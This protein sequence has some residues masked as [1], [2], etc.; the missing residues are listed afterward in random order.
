MYIDN[1]AIIG[2]RFLGPTEEFVAGTSRRCRN[3]NCLVDRQIIIFPD[4]AC[5]TVRVVIKPPDVRWG[6]V[7]RGSVLGAQLHGI[8]LGIG[9][10]LSR[11]R[12][13]FCVSIIHPETITWEDLLVGVDILGSVPL[14][15]HPVLES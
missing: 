4:D 2:L 9:I 11:S 6:R 15:Y 5:I 12:F 14:L 8:G 10:L 1:V 3:L 7:L 13:F